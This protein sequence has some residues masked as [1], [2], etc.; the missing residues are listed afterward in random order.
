MEER[1]VIMN[2]GIVGAGSMGMLFAAKCAQSVTVS[3]I[4]LVTRKAEQAAIIN[5]QGLR[6]SGA[7]DL[8]SHRVQAI[9]SDT[10]ELQRPPLDWLFV[11]V[12]QHHF[13]EGLMTYMAYWA[14]RGTK[15]LCFQN[16]IG[17]IERL[18]KHIPIQHIFTAVT[19]EAALRQ[20]PS[21]V[22]HT[23]SGETIIGHEA[24]D[25]CPEL[26]LKHLMKVLKDAGFVVSLSKNMN[27]I[28]WRKLLINAV[29][30]PLTAIMHVSNGQ[31]L[32]CEHRVHLMRTLL[33]EGCATA[34]SIGVDYPADLWE[35]IVDV[36]HATAANQSSML[37]DVLHERPTEIEAINGAIIRVAHDNHIRVPTHEAVYHII[38][39]L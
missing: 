36:C 20:S 14:E 17:H 1:G 26:S 13:D 37:Q 6:V 21:E 33:E 28:V 9:A 39:G 27:S 38:K 23:G 25:L 8:L 30:N 4:Y 35:Q 29:I 19:T 3:N 31:L 7:T 10:H 11:F 12:K 2:I 18:A 24:E 34:R 22:L 32:K 16:G 5:E 15:L